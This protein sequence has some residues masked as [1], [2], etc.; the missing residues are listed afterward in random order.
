MNSSTEP[1]YRIGID[2][3]G[4]GTRAVLA[5][6][7]GQ[8][9]GRGRAGPSA[10][11]QGAE[12]AWHNVRLAAA[13]AFSDAS[14]GPLD[15][16]DLKHCAIGLGLAG[17]ENPLWVREFHSLAPALASIVLDSDGYAALLGAHAGAPG[18]LVAVG[19]GSI[20]VVL[21]A[22]GTRHTVGGW[23]WKLG[24]E[25]GGGW[26]GQNAVR[27][28]QQVMD[29]RV[30]GGLA[31]SPL[32][33]AVAERC[34]TDRATLL[35]WTFAA[36]QRAYAALAPLVADCEATDPA[37][38]ALIAAAL[39]EVQLM[40]DALDPR[41]E[42]PLVLTGSIGVLLKPRLAPRLRQRLTEPAGDAADG[43]LHLLRR[44]LAA[45]EATR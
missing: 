28:T 44:H 2:G 20:G 30:T 3:G 40:A 29:G 21:R 13:G 34:G 26:F 36:D 22:D 12:Q 32:A 43:A 17:A 18:S 27:H 25:A 10:L 16:E 41:A 24:D 4:T 35:D 19:T 31:A 6:A 8:L 33:R 15:D 37:A 38:A 42:L 5:A 14:L 11:A 9:L 23:G 45:Q 39:D 7:D 1:R